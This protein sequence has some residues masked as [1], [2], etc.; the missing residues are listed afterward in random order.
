MEKVENFNPTVE[1]WSFRSYSKA[2]DVNTDY[3]AVHFQNWVI[4][5]WCCQEFTSLITD[6]NGFMVEETAAK[7]TNKFPTKQEV[8]KL[9]LKRRPMSERVKGLTESDLINLA[10]ENLQELEETIKMNIINDRLSNELHIDDREWSEE[11]KYIAEPTGLS[12]M[13]IENVRA[14]SK[15]RSKIWNHL[16]G[17]DSIHESLLMRKK[18][19]HLNED[20][21]QYIARLLGRY[22]ESAKVWQN[23]FRLSRATVKRITKMIRVDSSFKA[24]SCVYSRAQKFISDKAK[25]LIRSFLCPPCQPKSIPMFK[26]HIELELE[27]SYSVQ[28]IRDFVRIEMKYAYKKGCSRPPVYATK[29]AQLVKALFW[30]ELLSLISKGEVIINCDE[31]SYDR[32]IK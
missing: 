12:H 6:R 14:A 24:S 27:E 21:L 28:K 3:V 10:G 13:T 8:N 1:I 17:D 7:L 11:S 15:G 31:S 4:Y 9:S 26:S 2:E 20:Q 22:P 23:K 29:R 30:T 19:Q 16:W 32:S 18:G 25:Q 5:I